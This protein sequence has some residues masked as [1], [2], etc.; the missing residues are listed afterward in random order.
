MTAPMQ[1]FRLNVREGPESLDKRLT[2]HEAVCAERYAA[3]LA[4][5]GRLERILIAVAGALIAGMGG[6]VV[7]LAA[8]LAALRPG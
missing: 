8:A 4:R 7:K 5:L 1:Q 3:L 6:L 2:V